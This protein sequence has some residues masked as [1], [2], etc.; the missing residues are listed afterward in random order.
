MALEE[1]SFESFLQDGRSSECVS[2][3]SGA[4]AAG[5]SHLKCSTTDPHC[6]GKAGANFVY[7]LDYRTYLH[8]F[9]DPNNILSLTLYVQPTKLNIYFT[10]A[11]FGVNSFLLI[12]NCSCS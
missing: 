1:E 11:L 6:A 10:V 4:G 9:L 7:G 2:T 5:D 3:S 8:F 12:P